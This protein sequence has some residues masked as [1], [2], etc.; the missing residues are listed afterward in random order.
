[1]K[2]RYDLAQ[3]EAFHQVVLDSIREN[4]AHSDDE[5]FEGG[6]DDASE[7]VIY[8][9]TEKEGRSMKFK[10][11]YRILDSRRQRLAKGKRR[12]HKLSFSFLHF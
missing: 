9:I 5:L 8:H 6:Q 2:A 3:A 11:F 12:L 4:E 7:A 1:M 10:K